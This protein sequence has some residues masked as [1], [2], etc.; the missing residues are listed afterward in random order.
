[1]VPQVDLDGKIILGT[2]HEIQMQPAGS[3]AI[4]ESICNN[5]KV[6]EVLGLVEYAQLVDITNFCNTIMDPVSIG[7]TH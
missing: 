6:K 5:T 1:M 3:G 4:F 7:F 2:T